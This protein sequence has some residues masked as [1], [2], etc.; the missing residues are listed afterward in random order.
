MI[1]KIFCGLLGVV[2][3]ALAVVAFLDDWLTPPEHRR[4][5]PR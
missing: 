5:P 4:R 1:V 3:L 2:V